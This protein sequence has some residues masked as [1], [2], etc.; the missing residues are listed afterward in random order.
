M[1]AF[2]TGFVLTGLTGCFYID[3]IVERPR[4]QIEVVQPSVITRGG[5]VTLSAKFLDATG[6][7][8]GTYDWKLFSCLDFGRSG[9]DQC[10][11][12]AFYTATASRNNTVNFAVPVMNMS[13]TAKT[14]AISVQLE[15]RS[16]RGAVAEA[17][18][19]S[20]FE[21]NDAP[22]NLT[23][24]HA[25]VTY[26]VGAP[27]DLFALYGDPDDTL[28]EVTLSWQ[29]T[30]AA[31]LDDLPLAA[32]DPG[33]PTRSAAKRMVPDQPG[34][35]DIKVIATDALHTAVE[36]HLQFTVEPDHPPCLAQWE[37]IAPPPG[38][39]LPVSAP[40]AFQVPLVAD[41]LDAFPP[42]SDAPQ[43]GTTRFAWS[44]LPPGAPARQVLAGATGNRLAFDPA[45][46]TPGDLVELR[47]EAFDRH[48]TALPCA[49]GEPTCS[50]AASA[51]CIQRQ[52]WRVEIR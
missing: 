33:D 7:G 41:D 20:V 19:Q 48:G 50:I 44:I 14:A 37:P 4:V 43:F 18:G 24:R 36:R 12:V 45:A 3:P 13:R 17:T 9:S 47:V 32:P 38:A 34:D 39:T 11:A 1:R 40:T 5:G 26:T 29:A 27:I 8:L 49:D 16:D 6:T 30:P 22:P 46:Y 35:W 2:A 23:L 25:A 42:A 15:A 28:D 51:A 21:V 52:T 31:A 10:D